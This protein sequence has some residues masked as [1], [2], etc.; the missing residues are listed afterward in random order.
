MGRISEHT[1]GKGAN[2]MRVTA[3]E[4]KINLGKYIEC[5]AIRD[6]IITRKGKEV[7]PLTSV[8]GKKKD[9]FRSLR[10]LIKGVD[11]TVDEIRNER[12]G[13]HNEDSTSC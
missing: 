4:L 6:I 2:N 13:R 1:Y 7:A 8:E 12:L 10:G 11:L 9:A 5:A 3:A